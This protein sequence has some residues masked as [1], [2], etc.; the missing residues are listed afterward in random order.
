LTTIVAACRSNMLLWDKF[1][2]LWIN[3]FRHRGLHKEIIDRPE[4]FPLMSEQ[5]HS[6]LPSVFFVYSAFYALYGNDALRLRQS[7][8]KGDERLFKLR[9]ELLREK[10]TFAA[11]AN[12]LYVNLYYPSKFWFILEKSLY[13]KR[14]DTFVDQRL[15]P[16]VPEIIIYGLMGVVYCMARWK[17][18]SP[19][20]WSAWVSARKAP[21]AFIGTSIFASALLLDRY[22]CSEKMKSKVEQH[23]LEKSDSSALW[24]WSRSRLYYF[25]FSTAVF[26]LC[27]RRCK[28][29]LL[30]T[31]VTTLALELDFPALLRDF[32]V[33]QR[34]F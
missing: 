20:L 23:A 14:K 30:P 15:A 34:K 24:H 12:A 27:W 8:M 26:G 33:K 22:V 28:F 16:V 10:G 1:E 19:L 5:V 11:S 4:F 3:I 13:K 2:A 25:C 17:T 29:I 6:D 32:E 31:L 18:E 7:V 21:L 9:V